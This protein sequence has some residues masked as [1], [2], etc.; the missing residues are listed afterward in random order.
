MTVVPLAF[1]SRMMRNSTATSRSV[2]GAVGSSM[3]TSLAFRDTVFAIS[4]SCRYAVDR[5][6]TSIPAFSPSTLNLSRISWALL[7]ISAS[8]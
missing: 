3:M 4:T 6:R 2:R 8:F 5:L 7:F 1:I